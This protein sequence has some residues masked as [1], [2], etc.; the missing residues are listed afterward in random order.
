MREFLL[1]AASCGLAAHAGCTGTQ[2]DYF[3]LVLQWAITECAD[4]FKCTATNQFFTLHGLWP[5]LNNGN[6]PCTCTDAK[7]DVKK[8]SS[9]E[10]DLNTYW[11]SLNG[12][13]PTFWAHEYEKHGTCAEDVFPSELAFFNGTLAVRA[14]FDV[15][16]ALAK[17][18]ITPSNTKGFTLSA[19]RKAVAAAYGQYPS[20]Q[21]DS[22]GNIGVVTY[23]V[24]KDLGLIACPPVTPDACS[25][26]TLY[27]PASMQ[28]AEG[29][30]AGA[31]G[32]PR[33]LRKA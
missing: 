10:G 24:G 4:V 6:Y 16:P 7:F 3:E 9:I 15:V 11:P 22:A 25:A 21:C 29:G 33:K 1:L 13:S 23:C 32:W 19:F 31:F 2:Y 28:Q 30:W 26:S 27:L 14:A 20:V 5:N 17:G 12:P 18:G 8:V